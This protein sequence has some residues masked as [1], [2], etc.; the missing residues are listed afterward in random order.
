MAGL[1]T[2]KKKEREK[3][4]GDE[5]ESRLSRKVVSSSRETARGSSRIF[6]KRM[7][8]TQLGVRKNCR[9]K[10]GILKARYETARDNREERQGLRE[11]TTGKV[12]SG[13]KER[14]ER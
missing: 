6:D 14:R 5:S 2:G 10:V 1:F 11:R 12:P 3:R 4:E 13:E 9:I 8:D 7:N